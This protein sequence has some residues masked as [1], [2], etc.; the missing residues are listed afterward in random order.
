MAKANA[1]LPKEW[2]LKKGSVESFYTKLMKYLLEQNKDIFPWLIFSMAHCF[3]FSQT[4]PRTILST[5]PI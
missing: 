2:C 3:H 4:A 1:K 5:L